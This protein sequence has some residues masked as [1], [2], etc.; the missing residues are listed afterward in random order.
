MLNNVFSVSKIISKLILLFIWGHKNILYLNIVYLKDHRDL[1]EEILM[2][3]NL[4]LKRKIIGL[5]SKGISSN[6]SGRNNKP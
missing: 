4:H 2:K 5:I 1:A 6:Q 3:I